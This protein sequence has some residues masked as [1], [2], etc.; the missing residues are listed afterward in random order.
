MGPSSRTDQPRAGRIVRSVLALTF[1]AVLLAGCSGGGEG[2]GTVDGLPAPPEV[3]VPE[4]LEPAVDQATAATDFCTAATSNGEAATA[5]DA[6]L[7]AGE[8]PHPE[9]ELADL[10]EPLRETNAQMAASAPE[11][12]KADAEQLVTLSERRLDILTESGGDVTA[13]T[14]DEA[15]QEEAAGAQ[16]AAPR[17]RTFVRTTCRVDLG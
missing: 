14:T 16:E 2:G 3:E 13:I 1:G 4:E 8:P 7:G 17:F 5:L 11:Q 6:F 12:A 10:I 9:D 15:Y